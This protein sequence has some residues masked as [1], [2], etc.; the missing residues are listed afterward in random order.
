MSEILPVERTADL[1]HDEEAASA[2]GLASMT[3]LEVLRSHE[4]LRAER[5]ELVR[6]MSAGWQPNTKADGS[7]EWIRWTPAIEFE[8]MSDD[9]AVLLGLTQAA[10]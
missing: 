3:F 5:D 8:P 1:L 10:P 9:M 2:M 6:R 4:A 7:H